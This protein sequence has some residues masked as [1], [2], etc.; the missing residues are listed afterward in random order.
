MKKY[1]GLEY[2]QLKLDTLET[3]IDEI[4]G[5]REFSNQELKDLI[6]DF[7]SLLSILG[8]I[9]KQ[10]KWL[11]EGNKKDLNGMFGKL[12]E[13]LK[14]S[15]NNIIKEKAAN[16]LA[17]ETDYSYQYDFEKYPNRT[18]SELLANVMNLSNI[19]AHIMTT[20]KFRWNIRKENRNPDS[21]IRPLFN[22]K[23]NCIKELI[24]CKQKG[25][26]IEINRQRIGSEEIYTITVP[27]Y[28][29]A[30]CV[31]GRCELDEEQLKQCEDPKY[32]LEGM[33][34]TEPFKI[35]PEKH[36]LLAYL[37]KNKEIESKDMMQRI[38]LYLK[39]QERF[40]EK[41]KKKEEEKTIEQKKYTG[42]ETKIKENIKNE[43]KNRQFIDKINQ[44]LGQVF[45]EENIE[46]F[47]KRANYSF[48]NVYEKKLKKIIYEKLDN[49]EKSEENKKIEALKVFVYIRISKNISMI[50]SGAINGENLESLIDE[51]ITEYKKAY[52]Y[53]EI[54]KGKNASYADI[55]KGI[56]V[57]AKKAQ[58]T[59]ETQIIN[60]TAI[61]KGKD[62][63][64]PLEKN[65]EIKL[66]R[67]RKQTIGMLNQDQEKNEVKEQI[68]TLKDQKTEKSKQISENEEKINQILINS[69][70]STENKEQIIKEII[71]LRDTIKKL[72]EERKRIK[73]QIKMHKAHKKYL[74]YQMKETENS[75]DDMLDDLT[76]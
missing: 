46:D 59:E 8:Y 23:H 56:K 16:I 10:Y 14:K 52:E 24:K 75:R 71:D 35:S 25:E 42:K 58:K 37:Y 29:E 15:S 68:K 64:K 36:M 6:E 73:E 34:S 60:N 9:Q 45:T 70:E 28:F 20:N 66:K 12:Q 32:F 38:E 61:T 19:T 11:N 3:I 1:D 40:K 17:S 62:Q 53:L 63:E 51:S 57:Y 54:F 47:V 27:E 30:F 48:E 41:A 69:I 55:K 43:E 50:N 2:E 18:R 33:K 65:Q 49:L 44:Q 4:R 67:I 39:A 5:K 31:H 72:K 74:K 22:L 13:Y 76:K 26:D 7:T 21:I